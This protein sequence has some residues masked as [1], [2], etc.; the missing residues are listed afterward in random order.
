M[1]PAFASTGRVVKQSPFSFLEFPL[2]NLY[3]LIPYLLT[4]AA[5]STWL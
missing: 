2:S 4:A 5:A 3:F 1:A